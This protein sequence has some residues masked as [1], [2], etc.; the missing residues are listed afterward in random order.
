[1]GPSTGGIEGDRPAA[2]R[3]VALQAIREPRHGERRVRGGEGGMAQQHRARAGFQLRIA[4]GL[5]Q[6]DELGRV[7]REA[8]HRSYFIGS[9]QR[10]STVRRSLSGG[11]TSLFQSV[12]CAS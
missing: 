10:A 4:A 12:P 5:G 6:R 2:G 3:Y 8:L 9:P 1:M 7:R 11:N